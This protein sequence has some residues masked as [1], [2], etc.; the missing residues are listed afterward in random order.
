[1]GTMLS[2]GVPYDEYH[3][4][5]LST[6]LFHSVS[7]GFAGKQQ[8][9]KDYV[10]YTNKLCSRIYERF[11][12]GILSEETVQQ[13]VEGK[14]EVYMLGEEVMELLR[15]ARGLETEGE[16]EHELGYDDLMKLTKKEILDYFGVAPE[17][18]E[19]L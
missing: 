10:D 18:Q 1:M 3:V 11:Y 9:M 4:D 12:K 8:D 13:M 19:K 7:Y 14:S 5:P 17:V 15:K 16:N 6:W 2:L